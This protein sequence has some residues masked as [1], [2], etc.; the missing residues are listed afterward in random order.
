VFRVVVPARHDSSRLPGKVLLPIAG[1]SMLEWVI[2]RARASSA[3]EVWVA[4]D[5]ERIA[6]VARAFGAPVVMTSPSHTSGTDRIAEA[7]WSQR[8]TAEDIIVNL[9]A[10]EPL[11]PPT[12][13]NQVRD[14]L[15][16]HAQAALA[17]LA[18]PIAS[19]EDLLD[20]NAV[21]VVTTHG[22]RALYFSRAPI[23]WDRDGAPAGLAS[24]RSFAG[25]LKHIGM[26]A[27]RVRVL[28]RLAALAP[29]PLE[30]REK[31][32]QLRA[33]ENDFDIRVGIA[34]ERPGSDVN[35]AADLERVRALLVRPHHLD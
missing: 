33:L 30:L 28:Q 34:A 35:T 8:W 16:R 18:T 21:K 25:A 10:D 5:D 27:Y 14:L 31:L 13:I 20:P 2:E 12:L 17:T 22:E 4:T 6:T 24:Q 29:S 23:P 11:M 9:Q 26:Y 19:L 3:D 15:E 1:R 32:E 7:A